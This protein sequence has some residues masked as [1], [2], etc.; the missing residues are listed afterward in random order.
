MD[1]VILGAGHLWGN[2]P[3]LRATGVSL[4]FTAPPP[5]PSQLDRST[6][7]SPMSAPSPLS[8][9]TQ[10]KAFSSNRPTRTPPK[11]TRL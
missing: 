6:R 2:L 11:A 9:S 7:R 10:Y 3:P 5:T 1:L 8:L 4:A